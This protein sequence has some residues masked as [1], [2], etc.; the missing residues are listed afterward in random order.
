MTLVLE[1]TQPCTC[2]PRTQNY[3]TSGCKEYHGIGL[4]TESQDKSAY[5]DKGHLTRKRLKGDAVPSKF[6]NLPKYLSTEKPEARLTHTSME[7]RRQKE[8]DTLQKKVSQFFGKDEVTDFHSLEKKKGNVRLPGGVN[9]LSEDNCILFLALEKKEAIYGIKFCLEIA[10]DLVFSMMRHDRPLK[11]AVVSH[12]LTENKITKVSQIE[13]ILAYLA[14]GDCSTGTVPSLPD[15][16]DM[17]CETMMQVDMNDM[18]RN[19]CSFLCEQ[20]K[21]M[22]VPLKLRRYSSDLLVAATLWKTIWT[23]QAA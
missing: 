21:L 23:L 17:F 18:T 6:P 11:N 13:N 12:I 7:C 3:K 9:V 22:A 14:N 2:S 10:H 15:A 16:I 8:E 4:T 20:L 1:T 5:R 19:K